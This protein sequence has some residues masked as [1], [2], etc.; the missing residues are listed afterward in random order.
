M[1]HVFRHCMRISGRCGS[2]TLLCRNEKEIMNR[3]LIDE[4]KLV[5]GT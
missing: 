4:G 1:L 5:T 3:R 2:S